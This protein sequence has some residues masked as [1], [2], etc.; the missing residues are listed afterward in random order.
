MGRIQQMQHHVCKRQHRVLVRRC[1]HCHACLTL[2]VREL[3]LQG[4][5]AS[6]SSSQD[7]IP[8]AGKAQPAGTGGDASKPATDPTTSAKHG[9]ADSAVAAAAASVGTVGDGATVGTVE[10]ASAEDTAELGSLR[11]EMDRLQTERGVLAAKLGDAQQQ[12]AEARKA[13]DQKE[14]HLQGLQ[15]SSCPLMYSPKPFS[16]WS[17]VSPLQTASQSVQTQGC[18]TSASSP[19]CSLPVLFLPACLSWPAPLSCLLL[20]LPAPLFAR[21]SVTYQSA[22]LLYVIAAPAPQIVCP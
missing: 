22:Y 9:N 17:C 16:L 11:A 4:M 18:S 8:A 5:L 10:S 1:P 21:L 13:I 12:L 19:L 15:V 6:S 2:Q 20:C 7:S 3:Q 14:G